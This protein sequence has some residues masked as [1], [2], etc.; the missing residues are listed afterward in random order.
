[1][2]LRLWVKV[3]LAALAIIVSCFILKGLNDMWQRNLDSCIAG[4]HTEYWCRKNL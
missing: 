1:M 4:G 2:K 3:V